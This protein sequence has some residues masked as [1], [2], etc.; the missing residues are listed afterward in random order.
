MATTKT[1]QAKHGYHIILTPPALDKRFRAFVIRE[2]G[3]KTRAHSIVI[4][5]A[6]REL[7]D[8]EA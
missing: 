1:K 7:L 6:I 3:K 8:R 2:H 4:R 5:Q